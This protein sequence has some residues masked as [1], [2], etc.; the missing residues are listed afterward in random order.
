M[1][2]NKTSVSQNFNLSIHLKKILQQTL[3]LR[4]LSKKQSIK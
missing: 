4:A 2:E 1:I 3:Y